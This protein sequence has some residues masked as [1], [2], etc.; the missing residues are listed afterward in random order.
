MPAKPR[1]PRDP[2]KEKLWRRIIRRHQ[3][4]DLPVRAF[5]QNEG[6]KVCNFLWWRRELDRR[7]RVEAGLLPDSSTKAPAEPPASHVFLP[8]R[9]VDAEFAPPRPAP[10]I[11]IVLNGGPAVRVPVGFGPRTLGDILAV[12]EGRRC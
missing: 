2:A 10:P 9:V 11:E 12:L 8:V 6:L 4:S 5:C 1:R 7:D 3:Q